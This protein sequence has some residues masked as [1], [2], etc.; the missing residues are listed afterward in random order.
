ML[1]EQYVLKYHHIP[2]IYPLKLSGPLGILCFTFRISICA[3]KRIK[4]LH[5]TDA[6]I[7]MCFTCQLACALK[8]D[9]KACT[10]ATEV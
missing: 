1:E 4:S 9:A 2:I 6:I 8:C 5:M 3:P 7:G 10:A